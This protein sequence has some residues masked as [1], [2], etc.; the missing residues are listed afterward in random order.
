M[1][2]PK[3]LKGCLTK[4]LIIMEKRILS[5]YIKE[6]NITDIDTKMDIAE[7]SLIF[8]R[9]LENIIKKPPHPGAIVG[10]SAQLNEKCTEDILNCI[11]KRSGMTLSSLYK[12]I[13]ET[14]IFLDVPY[15][16]SFE[17]IAKNARMPMKYASTAQDIYKDYVTAYPL[18][19]IKNKPSFYAAILLVVAVARGLSKDQTLHELAKI[20]YSEELEIL[21]IEKNIRDFIGGNYGIKA[22][23]DTKIEQENT[24]TDEM[25]KAVSLQICK[26]E[27]QPKKETKQLKLSFN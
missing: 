22:S 25:R 20:T 11:A 10:L 5:P 13:T 23:K 18:D 7:K 1:Q 14:R 17:F 27:A 8:Y 12:K 9:Q 16:H 26:M 15:S 19:K 2:Q 21:S 6:I 4:H 24:I 3:L